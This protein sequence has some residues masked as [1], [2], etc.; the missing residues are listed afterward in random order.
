M[1]YTEA[2]RG[3]ELTAVFIHAKGSRRGTVFT[4]VCLCVCV[5]AFL[6]DISNTDA[7]RNTKLETEMFHCES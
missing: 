2:T 1:Q 4:A 7:A 5:P 3:D 6:H